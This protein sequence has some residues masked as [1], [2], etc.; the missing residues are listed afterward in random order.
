MFA[1][2]IKAEFRCALLIFIKI[3]NSPWHWIVK[4]FQDVRC[5]TILCFTYSLPHIFFLTQHLVTNLFLR[6][7]QNV[8]NWIHVGI[9]PAHSR[10]GVPLHSMNVLVLLELWHGARL[11]IKIHHFFGNTTHW[12]ESVFC[13]HNNR[14][15]AKY[16]QTTVKSQ[17]S[18]QV[19]GAISRREILWEKWMV[20]WIMGNTRWYYSW[21]WNHIALCSNRRAISVCM[22]SRYAITLKVVEHSCNVKEYLF[23]NGMGIRQTW[24]P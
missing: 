5:Y 24:I 8:F 11:C 14:H 4:F 18:V 13:S 16:I 1:Y 7:I 21:Y 20:S 19:L 10:R 6:N 17:V 22:I 9:F 2:I 12:H 23:W 3:C 15:H